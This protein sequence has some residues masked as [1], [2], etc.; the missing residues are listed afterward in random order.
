MRESV[1][2]TMVCGLT[3]H[4]LMELFFFLSVYLCAAPGLH[5]GIQTLVPSLGIEPGPPASGA[6]GLPWTTREVPLLDL[7]TLIIREPKFKKGV[8]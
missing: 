1:A 4:S 5:R 7:L 2:L 6:Q 3:A 8:E